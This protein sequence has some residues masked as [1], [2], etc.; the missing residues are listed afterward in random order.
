MG[1]W[2]R[3]QGWREK[4]REER[5]KNRMTERAPAQYHQVTDDGVWPGEEVEGQYAAFGLDT[6]CSLQLLTG[7]NEKLSPRSAWRGRF[8]FSIYSGPIPSGKVPWKAFASDPGPVL[9]GEQLEMMRGLTCKFS[10]AAPRWRRERCISHLWA[11][12]REGRGAG[13]DSLRQQGK[14]A[15]GSLCYFPRRNQ[16]FPTAR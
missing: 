15:T 8:L 3:A 6:L 12:V 10:L 2:E 14:Q 13:L 11:H 5:D 4:G 1:G 16:R 7:L 9:F